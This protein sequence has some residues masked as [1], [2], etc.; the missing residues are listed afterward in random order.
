MDVRKFSFSNRVIDKWNPLTDTCVNCKTVNN[1]NAIFQKNWNQ[2][3]VTY[4]YDSVREYRV[5]VIWRKPV[6]TNAISVDDI[7]DH[8]QCSV[9]TMDSS[10]LS[11]GNA[12]SAL[13]SSTDKTSTPPSLTT[14]LE[15]G[16]EVARSRSDTPGNS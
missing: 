10:S 3:P 5:G 15:R 11:P 9:G 2:K 7:D 14:T 4:D 1:L 6:L 13:R 16:R 8:S 12:I